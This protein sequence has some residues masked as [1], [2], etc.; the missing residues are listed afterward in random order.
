MACKHHSNAAFTRIELLVVGLILVLLAA[1][2]VPGMIQRKRSAQVVTCINNLKKVALCELLWMNDNAKGQVSW[3]IST[4]ERGTSEFVK[5]GKLFPHLQVLAFSNELF[6]PTILVCPADNRKPAK[7][8]GSLADSNLSYFVNLDGNPYRG[9]PFHLD[10]IRQVV[11]L[12]DR[13]ITNGTPPRAGIL[14]IAESNYRSLEWDP[15]MHNQGRKPSES[16]IGNVATLDGAVHT[17]RA[18]NLQRAFEYQVFGDVTNR[19]A[20]P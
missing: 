10:E 15:R 20:I 12:G 17:M 4:N 19:L 3:Q 2:L 1:V 13:N 18:T 7:S 14:T 11:M 5:E 9:V 8:F 16:S 6:T